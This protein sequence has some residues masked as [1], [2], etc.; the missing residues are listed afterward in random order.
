[1]HILTGRIVNS[2]IPLSMGC[3]VMTMA[4]ISVDQYC[5]VA[6]SIETKM[7]RYQ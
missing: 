6:K 1:M 3:S 5:A 4:L 7:F 2:V